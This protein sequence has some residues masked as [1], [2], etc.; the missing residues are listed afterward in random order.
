MRAERTVAAIAVGAALAVAAGWAVFAQSNAGE[1]P[2]NAEPGAPAASTAAANQTPTEITATPPTLAPPANGAETEAAEPSNEAAPPKPLAEIKPPPLPP[3]AVRSPAAI[4]R[5]LDKVTAET[6][7]F[8]A[9]IGQRIRYKNLV[10]TVKACE[11]RDLGGPDPQ[12]SAYMVV[13]SEPQGRAAERKPVFHGWMFSDSP[14]LHPLQH[15]VYDAWL[16]ACMAS[17]PAT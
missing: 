4:L 8:A 7:P 13:E 17:A 16:I 10:F 15:P 3:V 5:V 12:A 1:G 14:G 9:P 11:T 2:S 6:M